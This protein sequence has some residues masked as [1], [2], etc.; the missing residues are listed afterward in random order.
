ML[1]LNPVV[2]VDHGKP[3]TEQP[4]LD[5]ARL[6]GWSYQGKACRKDF[7]KTALA[8]DE[9]LVTSYCILAIAHVFSATQSECS[10]PIAHAAVLSEPG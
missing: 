2:A 3:G 8:H 9:D 7:S 6:L 5:F 10:C 1:N 4:F